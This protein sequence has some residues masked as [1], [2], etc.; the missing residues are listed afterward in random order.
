MRDTFAQRNV[1][2]LVHQAVASEQMRGCYEELFNLAVLLRQQR[3]WGAIEREYGV[4]GD[5]GCLSSIAEAI[6]SKHAVGGREIHREVARSAVLDVLLA[7]VGG[8]DDVYLDGDAAA[9]FES[10]GNNQRVF[11]SLSSHFLASVLN[12]LLLRELPTLNTLEADAVRGA[13][14]QRANMIIGSFERNWQYT[15]DGEKQLSHKQLLRTIA[16]KN[17]WFENKLREQARP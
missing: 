8:D 4:P 14:T 15:Q 7:A 12:R 9:V 3:D 16:E 10:V 2:S 6:A 11:D 5:M 13:A 17:E 1:A